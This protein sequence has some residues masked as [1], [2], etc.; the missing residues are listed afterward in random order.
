MKNVMNTA[1]R[2]ALIASGSVKP[3]NGINRTDRG[4]TKQHGQASQAAAIA[5]RKAEMAKRK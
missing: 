3:T 2:Q 4:A 1:V 5:A